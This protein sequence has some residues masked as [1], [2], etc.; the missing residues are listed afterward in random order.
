MSSQIAPPFGSVTHA[1]VGEQSRS[2]QVLSTHAGPLSL[3]SQRCPGSH[4]TPGAH[5]ARGAARAAVAG[6]VDAAEPLRL[7]AFAP[8]PPAALAAGRGRDVRIAAAPEQRGRDHGEQQ[9]RKGPHAMDPITTAPARGSVLPWPAPREDTASRPAVARAPLRRGIHGRREIVMKS[10]LLEPFLERLVARQEMRESIVDFFTDQ[11]VT[12]EPLARALGITSAAFRP[13]GEL[14]L[15]DSIRERK[16][17]VIMN[18]ERTAIAG[19]LVLRDAAHEIPGD[20][21]EACPEAAPIHR[22]LDEVSRP[23]LE[24]SP[25]RAGN[26]LDLMFVLM[27]AR[28]EGQGMSW[29]LGALAALVMIARG[30]SEAVTC[31]TNPRSR[32]IWLNYGGVIV[33]RISAKERFR[34]MGIEL[35]DDEGEIALGH[36]RLTA[37][38]FLRGILAGR[39]RWV[40]RRMAPSPRRRR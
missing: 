31:I 26:T 24:Q 14:I 9:E 12:R 1:S 15:D 33:N 22:L 20:L 40:L 2:A 21:S 36:M 8:A 23:Y 19:I 38:S 16:C 28:Y 6:G 13:L 35:G 18:A 27:D 10:W 7:A 34:L 17:F 37:G 11:F 5:V 32:R 29:N 30:Y 3:G 39:A 25:P 4:W